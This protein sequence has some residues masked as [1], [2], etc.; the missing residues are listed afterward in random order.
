MG[1]PQQ[2]IHLNTK[3]KDQQ[4]YD[5]IVIGSGISGGWAAKELCE[6][7]LS[8][9]LLERGRN[10]EHVKDYPTA[11]LNPWDF[12]HR[13]RI[14]E[15]DK[16]ENPIQSQVYDEGNKLFYV[17][18]REHPYV[19]RQGA[20]N[21]LRGYHVGGRSLT[22]GRMCYRWSDLDFEANAKEGIGVDWPIRYKDIAPWYDYVEN[23]VGIS[24][25]PEGLPHL[26]DGQLLPPME[27]NFLE[28]HFK[29]QIQKHFS[30]R[31]VTIGRVANLSQEWK[32]R[33]PCQYRN[34]CSRGC[35]FGGYFSSNSATLPAALATGNLTLRPFS[36]V[37]EI[38]YDKDKKRATGVRII[39]AMTHESR[40]FYAKVIFLNAS[41]I[42]STAIL[43]QSKSPEFPDGL[44]NTNGLM[45]QFLM[46]HHLRVGAQGLYK[47]F[48]DEYYSGRRPNS[49]Y[50]PRF[51]NLNA[52]TA[53]TDYLRG[54]AYQ[55]SATREG[56]NE[57]SGTL[58][59]FGPDFKNQL[60]APGSWMMWM[61]S[62]G[63][64][65]PYAEN[66]IALSADKKDRWGLPVVEIDFSFQSNEQHMR[67]D[68]QQCAAEM[69]S[70]AGFSDV[71]EFDYHAPGGTAVHEMGTMRM[72]RDPKTSL[73]N[74]W[75]QLH[76]AHNLFV[77]D[78]SCMTSSAWQNPS[79]TYM[80]LTARACDFAVAELKRGNLP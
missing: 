22:W 67:K 9:L 70:A 18:D 13:L 49:L 56:W 43:L 1:A 24:G 62:W 8:T 35:P 33:G 79:L 59:G 26:P 16:A 76:S 68:S 29:D 77:T 41:T 14:T 39:D 6:K 57:Q 69:L 55:G 21:W 53:R 52:A 11:F 3:A 19:Q 46:D 64:T 66:K 5:A 65:L 27:M 61:G 44:G 58:P 25:Q 73:L 48:T 45:G 40:E 23:F 54:F 51:R 50:I 80:A 47:G 60:T 30:G 7:G 42:A 31:C 74:S 37:A 63:E 71:S 10:V 20:F 4:T 17:N 28:K 15:K 78:G 2:D 75:N 36:I 12:E 38:L 72:G 34:L 32:G